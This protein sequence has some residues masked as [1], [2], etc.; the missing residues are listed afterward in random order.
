MPDEP[1][2]PIPEETSP[3]PSSQE[4]IPEVSIPPSTSELA[5]VPPVAPESPP[6][7]ES[8]IPVIIDN[9]QIEPVEPETLVPEQTAQTDNSSS[10]EPV[11]EAP[12]QPT[13]HVP[14]IEPFVSQDSRLG[15]LAKAREAIQF[16]KRRK[17]EKI[18]SLFLK[19]A[20]ITN[21]EVEKLLHVS[22][23][24]ATRYL[25]QLE[26]EG[27]VKQ[28]GRTGTGVSYSRM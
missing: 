14:V 28:S 10:N 5:P 12:A 9:E 13:A 3:P 25:E 16:R 22:D 18:I 24:T 27:K 7:A 2:N 20:T 19:H 11:S 1:Q 8:A 17:L 15:W 26:K 21:D 23:A 4:P 6:E